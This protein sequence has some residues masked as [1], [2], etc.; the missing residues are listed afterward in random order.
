MSDKIT[1]VKPKLTKKEM[2]SL[3]REEAAEKLR[4]LLPEGSTVYTILRHVSKSGM[5]RRISVV[6]VRD[7]EIIQL[8]YWVGRLLEM[9]SRKEGLP[10]HGA[11]MDMGYHLVHSLQYAMGDNGDPYKLTHRW[12]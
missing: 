5:F 4:E 11:G 7:G 8:D 2:A 6:A 9:R 10:V 1:I 3:A 12:L